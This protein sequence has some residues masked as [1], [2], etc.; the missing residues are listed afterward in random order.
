MQLSLW[1]IEN[2]EGSYEDGVRKGQWVWHTDNG[3]SLPICVYKKGIR[4]GECFTYDAKGKILSQGVYERGNKEGPW[5]ETI[6]PVFGLAYTHKD[7][8]NYRNGRKVGEWVEFYEN[9]Q[10][11]S[12]GNYKEGK[13]VGPW[14]F[15]YVD[16]EINNK[17]EKDLYGKTWLNRGTGTYKDGKKVY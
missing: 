9:G 8:G 14:M 2:S 15:Y 3:K 16:G 11:K 7:K 12:K 17:G 10:I 1:V 6:S 4:D 13:R 5:V